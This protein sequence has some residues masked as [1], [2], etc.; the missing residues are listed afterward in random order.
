V[1]DLNLAAAYITALTG[2]AETPCQW[3]V[4]NDRVKGD[5]GRNIFGSLQ[6]VAAEL[7]QYNAAAWGIFVCINAMDGRGQKLEN[8]AY[9]RTHVADIDNTLVSAA[10]YEQAMRS[11]MPPQMAVQ[12][13]PGKFH[14]YWLTEAYTGNDFYSRQQRKLAQLYSAD[15]SITDATRVLRV[16]GFYHCKG[17]PVMVTCWQTF[18]VPRYTHAQIEQMLATVNVVD[19]YSTRTPLGDKKLAAP[20]LDVL[21]QALNLLHPNDLDRSEWMGISAAFKQ[22]GWTLAP[23]AQLIQI[24]ESWC[25][26]YSEN[27]PSE[28][29]KL[30]NSFHDTEVGWGRFKRLTNIEA[31]Q[32][33][34]VQPPPEPKPLPVPADVGRVEG[35]SDLL[36][37]WGKQQWFKDCYFVERLGEIL[38]PSGRFMNSTKFNGSYGGKQFLTSTAGG[39]AVNEAWVA[40]LRSTDW[41]IPKVD[42]I[43]FLPELKPLEIVRDRRGRKGINTYMPVIA[44]ARQGDVTLWID[45]IS[46]ILPNFS[47]RKIWMDYIAHIV[48]FPGYKVPWAP[49]MQGVEGLGKSVFFEVLQ[50]ALGEMYV[51]RPKAPELISSGSKFNAWMRSKL[52]IVVDEIKIDER[53]E[54]IE[55]LKPMITDKEIEIQGK[56]IDQE[57]EDNCANWVFF[58]NYK[59]AI[60][61]NQNGR[62]YSVF[63]S[64]LQT[65]KSLEEVGMNKAYFDRLW[66][67]L[68]EEGG[69]EA[70]TYWL[71]HYPIKRGELPINAPE[72]SSHA[73]VLRISRGPLEILFDEKIEIGE[74]GFRKGYV[75]WPLLMKAIAHSK[76][77]SIPAEH[78]IR[79]M[80]ENRGYHEIGYYNQILPVED[81]SRPPLLFGKD[82][83]LDP[84]GY[85]QAQM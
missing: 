81:V 63:Y 54:L 8:V 40:A 26:H 5:Q 31:Y 83:D 47:D 29:L 80:L 75:S 72:T 79:T 33:L 78:V 4:I 20:S 1:I 59:D 43:R 38:T 56:G 65:K 67:W 11:P 58:S 6:Q 36:D 45:H 28:N 74:R 84:L 39:K 18:N 10:S 30:W 34:G 61:V 7:Q 27:D 32:L 50:Y 57:M 60:P 37:T 55:I 85:E 42:H 71:Q 15:P 48:K 53:R 3:R 76:M 25:S 62:R 49:L 23:E 66:K 19:R 46:K 68:R 52:A 16:P 69:L 82:P 13:S 2:H 77:R 70:V 9:I 22:A 24:W 73:E 17:E 41:T 35:L 14:L 51:Y 64:A 21:V 12:T 44:S